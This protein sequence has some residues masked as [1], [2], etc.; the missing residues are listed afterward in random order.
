MRFPKNTEADG[1]WIAGE[2]QLCGGEIGG[3]EECY[4][5]NG[6]VF[7]TD[8]LADFARAYFAP[9]LQRGGEDTW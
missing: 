9:F 7:C 2:C 6:Q 8:C 4:C 3:G 5:V 1:S